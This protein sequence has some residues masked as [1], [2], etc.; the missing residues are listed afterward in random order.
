MKTLKITWLGPCPKCQGRVHSVES[1]NS[2]GNWLYEGEK[3]TCNKCGHKGVIDVADNQC[4]V[5]W[6]KN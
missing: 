4:E 1:L 2:A 5:N 6:S 3:V